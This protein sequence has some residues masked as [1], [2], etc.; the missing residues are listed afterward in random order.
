MP[1]FASDQATDAKRRT[2]SPC[3]SPPQ[4]S[5]ESRQHCP[6]REQVHRSGLPVFFDDEHHFAWAGCS[7]A[8]DFLG[9]DL[10]QR[11]THAVAN[12]F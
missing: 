1:D 4:E 10:F 11:G 9:C 3:A 5:M 12:L 6:E 2:L 7:S 8:A